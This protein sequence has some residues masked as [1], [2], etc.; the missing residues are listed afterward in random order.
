MTK[1]MTIE[2]PDEM[3]AIIAEHA[4]EA[5]MSVEDYVFQVIQ[6]YVEDAQDL[7][8][9]EAE[10]DRIESGESADTIDDFL[11]RRLGLTD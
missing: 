8:E 2:M 10:L 11:R 7:E 1:I 5:E 4:A 9:A 3:H 6:Q